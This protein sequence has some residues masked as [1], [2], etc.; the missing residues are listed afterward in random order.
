VTVVGA[1][2][3]VTLT[4]ATAALT[5]VVGWPFAAG[6]AALAL[7]DAGLMAAWNQ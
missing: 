4:V 1:V 3:T 2:Q 5:R 7:I 6:F